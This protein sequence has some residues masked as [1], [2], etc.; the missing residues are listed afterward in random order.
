[1]N[2]RTFY[3]TLKRKAWDI[4]SAGLLG[5]AKAIHDVHAKIYVN[6]RRIR[7][8]FADPSSTFLGNP[9][10]FAP[11]TT[12]GAVLDGDWDQRLVAFEDMDVWRAFR[13]RFQDG[14]EWS[15]TDFYRRIIATVDSGRQ[16]YG[17]ADQAAVD[18]R[19]K[20]I[21]ALY[22]NI[23]NNGYKAQDQLDG[24]SKNEL[25][26]DQDEIHVHISRTGEILF[27]DGQHRLCIAKLL[28]LN[29][30]PAKVSVRHKHWERLRGDLAYYAHGHGGLYAKVNHPDLQFLPC[31]HPS[32]DRFEIIQKHLPTEGGSVLDIGSHWGY[33]CQRFAQIGFKPTAVEYH[34]LNVEFLKRL[35]DAEDLSFDVHECSVFDIPRPVKFDV[36]LALNIFHHFLKTEDD[37]A[38]LKTLLHDIDAQC[39]FFQPHLFDEPQMAGSYK[40]Y[41]PLEFVEFVLAHSCFSQYKKIGTPEDGRD[42]YLLTI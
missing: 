14:V 20:T 28:G 35:R 1:M 37:E 34:S 3:G 33:F 24:T 19:M 30:V 18:M 39:M 22:N 29:S 5:K 2:I 15:S 6:P 36:V 25:F 16:L 32:D 26:V 4:K 9:F 42:I 8:T 12:H 11:I 10:E 31:H 40:N 17:C 13:A 7:R 27:A 23:K 38:K 21:D 41:P